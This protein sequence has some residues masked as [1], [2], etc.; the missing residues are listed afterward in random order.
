[1]CTEFGEKLQEAMNS[2]NSSV[3]VNKDGSTVKMI[4][5]PADEL[6]NCAKHCW[7]MLYND[8][9]FNVGRVIVKRNLQ[10]AWD[11]C[12]TELFVR[13]LLHE[14]DTE[15]KTRKDLLDY[16]NSCRNK[17]E[18]NIVD[19]SISVIFGSLS[20]IFEKV[21]IRKLMDACFDKL[22]VFNRKVITDKFLLSQGIW[23]T[24]QEKMDLTEKDETG[25]ARDKKVVI[26]ERLSLNKINP[27]Q[28]RFLTTGFSYNEFRSIVQM[29]MLAKI[30]S[31][32][33]NTLVTLRDKVILLIDNE[34][35]YHI[36]KWSKLL[37]NIM[38][39]ADRRKIPLELPNIPRI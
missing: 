34:L 28:I 2:I 16:I 39:V 21:T 10:K 23:L 38:E 24:D 17:T 5:M 15:L 22:D 1:M 8:D 35:D 12:N 14:C 32:P 18:E 25:K 19:S 9:T 33:S 3:W 26:C 29:P 31:L 20:P 13:Y 27:R 11:S 4:D 30:S 6:Q 7:E 37:K 36:N